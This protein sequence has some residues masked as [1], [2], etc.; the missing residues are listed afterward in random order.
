MKS[1]FYFVCVTFILV[2]CGPTKIDD[3]S[4]PSKLG[5][6]LFCAIQTNDQELYLKHFYTEE[7]VEHYLTGSEADEN[8]KKKERERQQERSKSIARTL[9]S[10]RLQ[11]ESKGVTDWSKAKFLRVTYDT[12]DKV[13]RIGPM[14]HAANL[15]LKF[16]Y[17]G[18]TGDID[19]GFTGF[20]LINGRW[21]N[22]SLPEFRRL[23]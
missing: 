13:N 17:V 6:T 21:R 5:E 8:T 18:L 15:R 23:K 14:S 10:I 1:I 19:F 11:A 12:R 9:Q 7:D 3:N 16:E 22:I 2:A 4:S 20:Y